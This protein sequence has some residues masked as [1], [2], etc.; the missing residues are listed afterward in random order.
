MFFEGG[1]RP[2]DRKALLLELDARG[3]KG[4][5]GLCKKPL[6]EPQIYCLHAVERASM[7]PCIALG[8]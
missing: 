6:E 4:S 2:A 8:P 7:M 1:P 5:K 3:H